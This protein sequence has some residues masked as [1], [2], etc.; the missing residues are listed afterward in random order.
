MKAKII[1]VVICVL[2]LAAA[3]T[4]AKGKPNPV[5]LDPPTD[6]AALQAM[7]PLLQRGEVSLVESWSNGRL[8]QVCVVGLVNAPPSV[9]WAVLTDYDNYK[10]IFKSLAELEVVKREGDD[11]VLAYELEVPGSN[12][13]YH[14]RHHHVAPSHIDITLDDDEGD[15]QTGAWRW[16]LVP[17]A[18]GLKTILVYTL[19]TDVRETS[20]ILRQVLKTSPSLEHGLNVATGLLTVQEVKKEAEKR[21]RSSGGG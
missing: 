10:S 12:L 17:N 18:E 14:L 11:I 7:V 15:L 3:E 16:D 2:S 19:Y 8:R 13:E 9:I 6:P 5:K 21:N 20:W 1:C 4:W